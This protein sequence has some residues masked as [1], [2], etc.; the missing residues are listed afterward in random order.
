MRIIIFLSLFHNITFSQTECTEKTKII[1]ENIITSIGNSFPSPPKLNF[2]DHKRAVAFL[3][4][5]GITIETPIINL[6][7][8]DE[9]FEDKIA[10]IISHELAHH[11]LSHTWMRNTGLGYASSI[12]EFIDEKSSSKDQRKLAESQADLFGGFFGQI[13]GYNVL[14]FAKSTLSDVYTHYNLPHEIKRISKF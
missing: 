13:A 7:C 10:Y 14:G 12:G 6:L 3:S 2:S 8:E 11:Y 5:E 1:Y 4:S 9:N